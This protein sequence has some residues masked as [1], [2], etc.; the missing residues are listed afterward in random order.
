MARSYEWLNWPPVVE[1][2]SGRTGNATAANNAS[3][4][5]DKAKKSNPECLQC[6]A[7]G[8]TYG[9]R[10]CH[11]AGKT[12]CGCQDSRQYDIAFRQMSKKA[13]GRAARC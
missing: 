6:K 5:L 4:I 12:R 2:N 10:D 8:E 13:G 3:A 1:R 9:D 7:I 11:Q